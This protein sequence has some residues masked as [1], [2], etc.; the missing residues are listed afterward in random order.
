[1]SFEFL[2][3]SQFVNTAVCCN[4]VVSSVSSLSMRNRLK[5][6]SLLCGHVVLFKEKNGY[7]YLQTDGFFGIN[8]L[9][10]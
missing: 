1:M 3:I 9:L 5:S 2:A 6:L 10:F 7:T 8:V 4:Y